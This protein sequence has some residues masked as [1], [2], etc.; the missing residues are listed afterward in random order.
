MDEKRENEP[1]KKKIQRLAQEKIF[2]EIAIF[3]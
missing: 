3:M 1:K 2:C